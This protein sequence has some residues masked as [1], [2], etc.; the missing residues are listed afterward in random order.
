[1]PREIR[2]IFF[3]EN[4]VKIALMRFSGR[5]GLDFLVENITKYDLN[6]EG[7]IS[8]SMGVFDSAASKTGTVKYDQAQVAAAMMG[9]CMK[10]E[11]PLPK[12]GKK[13]VM[14]KDEILYL[15]IR[16]QT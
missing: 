14:A 15:N 4:E 13:S 8:I 16:I 10:L 7:E 3:T 2:N 9:Y 12:A 6:T 1:M 5:Q 11:I